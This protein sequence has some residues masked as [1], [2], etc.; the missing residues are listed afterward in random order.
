[1]D[2]AVMWLFEGHDQSLH[3]C[4]VWHDLPDTPREFMTL[5]RLIT[6][7]PGVDVPGEVCQEGTAQARTLT[8]PGAEQYSRRRLAWQA[9]LRGVAAFP[10]HSK[11]DVV[12]V[13]EFFSCRAPR[14]DEDL[15]SM[16]YALGG[17]I[18]QMLQRQRVEQDLRNSEAL[19]QSLV[20][21]LPQNIYRKDCAGRVTF[22]N[23]HYCETLNLPIEKLLGKT[24][25]DL[26]PPELARKYTADDQQV[27]KGKPFEAV[28]EHHLPDGKTIFVQVVKTPIKDAQG[29]IVGTQ[30]LFWDVTEKHQS[31][32]ILAE[33]ELR[34]RQLTEASGGHR[35]ALVGAGAGGLP[36]AA[37]AGISPLSRDAAAAHHRPHRGGDGPPQGRRRVSGRDRPERLEPRRRSQGACAVSRGHPRSHRAQQDALG[38]GSQ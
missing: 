35:P 21:S 13:L 3:C 1:M 15:Q 7:S 28:E 10:I 24:D 32:R 17:Q 29:E 9:G 25:F 31:Q 38:A 6:I 11:L 34:Y 22:G 2:L 16:M 19:Y 18:G 37:R 36:A 14:L 33:S 30:G 26:F 4:E 8:E 27:L 20:Q 12:G 23:R 5:T